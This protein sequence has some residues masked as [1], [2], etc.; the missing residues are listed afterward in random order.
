M[1]IFHCPKCMRTELNIDIKQHKVLWANSRGGWGRGIY[2]IECP[3]C[4]NERSGYMNGFEQEDI[5]YVKHTI[6]I[7]Q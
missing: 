4:K 3:H 2:H 5:D 1:N 7:Y 6:S